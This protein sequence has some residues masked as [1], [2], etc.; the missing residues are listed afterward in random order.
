[1]LSPGQTFKI[2]QTCGGK[3]SRY[4][5]RLPEPGLKY[6]TEFEGNL[7]EVMVAEYVK[8]ILFQQSIERKEIIQINQLSGLEI[9]LPPGNKMLR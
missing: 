7:F 3:Q 1:M 5:S 9:G 6:Y 2:G 4:G 8:L